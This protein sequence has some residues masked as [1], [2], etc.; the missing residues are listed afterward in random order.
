M[1]WPDVLLQRGGSGGTSAYSVIGIVI[2]VLDII[3]IVS[4][5]K[6]HKAL[7]PKVVWTLVI[8][9][10]PIIGLILYFFLGREK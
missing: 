5:W 9:F 10:L 3:V 6:S 2:L 7:I 8:L 4:V 1:Q